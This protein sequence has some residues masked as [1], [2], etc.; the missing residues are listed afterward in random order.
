MHCWRRSHNEIKGRCNHVTGE[1]APDEPQKPVGH[2]ASPSLEA[3]AEQAE[4]LATQMRQQ[5][6]DNPAFA[7]LDE[8]LPQYEHATGTPIAEF[9]PFATQLTPAVAF[10]DLLTGKV[11][12]HRLLC[13]SDNRTRALIE[14]AIKGG[15]QPLIQAIV[16][17]LVGSATV[18]NPVLLAIAAAVAAI[19]L[20]RGIDGFCS[21][22]T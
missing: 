8:L 16:V 2:T 18:V 10:P 5:N 14:G 22:R 1:S 7:A 11:F 15:L 20:V 19:V 4:Q 21:E 12:A 3:A 6:S 17:A 9:I 13:S